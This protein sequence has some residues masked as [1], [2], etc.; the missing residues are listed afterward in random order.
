MWCNLRG[1]EWSSESEKKNILSAMFMC[2]NF[3]HYDITL[4][5]QLEED[6]AEGK[7]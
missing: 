6:G 3:N 2:L 7:L 1:M 5:F 4:G